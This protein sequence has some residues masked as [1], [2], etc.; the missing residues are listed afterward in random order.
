VFWLEIVCLL[1]D[2]S[3]ASALAREAEL[4]DVAFEVGPMLSQLADYFFLRGLIAAER[5]PGFAARRTLARCLR[6][7]RTW[8]RRGPDFVHLAQGIEAELAR[9]RGRSARALDLY[10]SAAQRAE[11][12]GHVHHAGLLHERRAALLDQL[13]RGTEAATALTAAIERY[14]AWG[15]ETKVAQLAQRR[16]NLSWN[17]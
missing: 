11:R 16:R 17:G 14:Q 15:A 9:R 13:R 4:D 1:G 8:A 12:Q 6:Q 10:Q 3:R 7:L 2:W 5:A